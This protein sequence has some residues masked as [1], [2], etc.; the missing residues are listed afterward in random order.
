VESPAPILLHDLGRDG[1]RITFGVSDSIATANTFTSA[2]GRIVEGHLA[3]P[4][5]RLPTNDRP[6]RQNKIANMLTNFRQDPWTFTWLSG[7]AIL[8][9]LITIGQQIIAISTAFIITNSAALLYSPF[10]GVWFTDYYSNPTIRFTYPSEDENPPPWETN[11]N[12][13]NERDLKSVSYAET[14]Y[15]EHA[16]DGEC[17]YYYKPTIPFKEINNS[18]CPFADSTCLYGNTGAYTVDTGYLDS[19]VLGFNEPVRC[20]FRMKSTCSPIRPDE[21]YV[22]S[23]PGKEPGSRKVSYYFGQFVENRSKDP[24]LTMTAT[25]PNKTKEYFRSL[26]SKNREHHIEYD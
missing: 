15:S 8:L 20:E 9:F 7:V 26:L 4:P 22:R 21:P 18:S 17:S 12:I 11:T 19:S 1:A 10:C 16:R 2:A 14:C 5:L 24:N 13:Q 25:F 6:T 3:M 23:E